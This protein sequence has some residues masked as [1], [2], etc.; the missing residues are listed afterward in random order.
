MDL[1]AFREGVGM[2]LGLFL[3]LLFGHAAHGGQL[4][5]M[6]PQ[7]LVRKVV[8]NELHA[9]KQGGINHT[10]RTRKETSSGSQ[11]RL[12]C[13]TRD[14]MVGLTLA[15]NDKPLTADELRGEEARLNSYVSDPAALKKKQAQEKADA[16][17]VSRIVRALPDAFLF[18]YDG[19][20]PG[21]TG[22][23]KEGDELVRLKFRP[24]PK[25]EPP[26]RV[27]QVLAGLQGYLLIDENAYRIAQIDG[28]LAKEVAFGWGILGHL[29]PGGHFLVEQGDVGDVA[30]E[31]YRMTLSFTGKILLFKRL[32]IRSN[33]V[34]SNFQR[35][36]GDLSFAQGVDL[37]KK[38]LRELAENQAGEGSPR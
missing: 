15:N 21:R 33:E 31:I 23:G 30:W 12:Y 18:D 35:V 38:H 29:D 4:P 7:E 36:P 26:S 20:E 16:D 8:Q 28:R 37:L 24:N 13:E 6:P 22:V 9:A 32:D 19:T 1:P 14:A 3:S 17:R 34:S 2:R 25:Y 27:E 10:F 5:P 11:T